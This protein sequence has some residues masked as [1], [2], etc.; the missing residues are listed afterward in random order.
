MDLL[1]HWHEGTIS[2]VASLVQL[3]TA[4]LIFPQQ[5]K[6]VVFFNCLHFYIHLSI[7]FIRKDSKHVDTLTYTTRGYFQALAGGRRNSDGPLTAGVQAASELVPAG[8][9]QQPWA[10]CCSRCSR[11]SF[12]RHA[13]ESYCLYV[14]ACACAHPPPPLWDSHAGGRLTRKD[15][16]D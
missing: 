14:S 4:L 11:C 10:T 6:V 1:M 12:T 16:L 8:C 5:L 2:A 3:K 15:K 13:L 9:R 7:F